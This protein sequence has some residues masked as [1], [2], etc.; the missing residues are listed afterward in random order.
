MTGR[1]PRHA[2]RPR[3]VAAAWA[4]RLALAAV[5]LAGAAVPAAAAD[6][7][8]P[9]LRAGDVYV[10]PRVLGPA[11]AA[12]QS[13]L[14]RNAAA[15]REAGR[16]VKLAVV[17]GPVGAPSLQVYAERLAER[18]DHRGTL[19]VTTPNGAVAG[20]SPV[21]GTDLRPVLRA[22]RVGRIVNPV[23]R[24]VRAARLTATPVEPE[25]TGPAPELVLIGIALLGGGWAAAVGLGREG[26]RRRLM[27]TESRAAMR[28]HL[29]AMR[30]RATTLARRPDLTPD[31]RER[32][33]GAL[34]TY[35]E[36]VSALQEA[37]TPEVIDALAPRVRAGVGALAAVA[38]EAGA[39]FSPERPF[40]GLCTVDPGH[41]PVVADDGPE[42]APALCATCRAAVEDG[43]VPAPRLLPRDGRPVPFDQVPLG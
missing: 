25:D 39:P 14:A 20:V 21:P 7:A 5:A 27:L 32:V 13:A 43:R 9:A 19:L 24:L 10:S 11:A 23:E 16:P 29:D 38:D 33:V 28:L 40:E 17:L 35:A 8:L 15:L 4:R 6:P 30:V 12:E 2:P 18:L 37:R 36:V 26:R 3:G 31:A 42:E 1:G 22:A 34:G 41:G